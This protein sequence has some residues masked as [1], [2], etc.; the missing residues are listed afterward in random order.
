MTMRKFLLNSFANKFIIFCTP[1]LLE[2]Y[3]IKVAV[4]RSKMASNQSY[5]FF[6]FWR[7]VVDSPTIVTTDL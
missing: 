2:S 3:D 1:E 6:S 7:K 5:S 4:V